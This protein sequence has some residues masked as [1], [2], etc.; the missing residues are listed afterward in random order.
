MSIGLCPFQI[1]S[2]LPS[3]ME[4]H[5]LPTARIYTAS[6]PSPSNYPVSYAL[7]RQYY[8]TQL[9]PGEEVP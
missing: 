3:L 9:T 5:Q 2:K 6:S 4:S 1:P 8:K 7:K